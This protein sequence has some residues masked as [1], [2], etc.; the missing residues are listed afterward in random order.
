MKNLGKIFLLTLLLSSLS[1]AGVSAQVSQNNISKGEQIKVTLEAQGTEVEFPT[2]ESIEKALG[3]SIENVGVSTQT[4]FS[5]SS[6]SGS[7]KEVKKALNFYF[8][9]DKDMQIP[10]FEIKVDGKA[11]KTNSINISVGAPQTSTVSDEYFKAIL[12][13]SK[14]E[15]M[16]G[17]PID[18]SMK[19]YRRRDQDVMKLHYSKPIF[20]NFEVKEKGEDRMRR[21]GDYLV[22]TLNYTIYP[23]KDGNLTIDPA[24]VKV[25]TPQRGSRNP[26]DIFGAM[27]METKWSKVVSNKLD[28][29]VKP[30]PQDASLIGQFDIQVSIDNQEVDANKPVKLKVVISGTGTLDSLEDIQYDLDGVTCFSDDANIDSQVQ[31]DGSIKSSYKKSFVFL[32]ENDFII[33][34]REIK[35]YNTATQK[36]EKLV[37]PEYSIK[38]KGSKKQAT[39]PAVVTT[40]KSTAQPVQIKTASPQ[41]SETKTVIK[42]S[43]N[44]LWLALAFGGGVLLTLLV[45]YIPKTMK[46]DKM[47]GSEDEVFKT[48]Y[49]NMDKDPRIEKIVR[50]MHAKKRGD[51][52]IVI[53]KK[54]IKEILEELKKF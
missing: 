2:N 46:M 24:I 30:I 47:F 4:F 12:S 15:A 3:Y 45:L 33:P 8:Y 16:V 6:N 38:V 28:I 22:Q 23:K 34:K 19:F 44:P 32:S 53:D 51:K 36:I 14:K 29:K 52:S 41:T 54:E 27:F 11:E 9:P 37:I 31:R 10:T 42:E 26:H 18:I 25:A 48:L 7:T 1:L 50:D 17:E 5:F 35:F 39:T 40:E 20:T 21:E 49:A 43:N 13:A